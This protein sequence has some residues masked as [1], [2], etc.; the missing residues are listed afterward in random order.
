MHPAI[1]VLVDEGIGNQQLL[2]GR[3][4]QPAS[5]VQFISDA[6]VKGQV[7]TLKIILELDHIR[8]PI[9][10]LSKNGLRST[11]QISNVLRYNSRVLNQGRHT[12]PMNRGGGKSI[13]SL[14]KF[15]QIHWVTTTWQL[16]GN[17]NVQ[18]KTRKLQFRNPYKS[19]Q[20]LTPLRASWPVVCVGYS[21]FSNFLSKPTNSDRTRYFSNLKSLL[22]PGAYTAVYTENREC[23]GK[24]TSPGRLLT[25]LLSFT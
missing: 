25:Q 1:S 21:F 12:S 9:T 8:Q 5:L 20:A 2:P 19:I 3:P 6:L 22:G 10:C 15:T 11:A 24:A 16:T 17:S 4:S 14:H 18:E 13:L 7:G 23:T